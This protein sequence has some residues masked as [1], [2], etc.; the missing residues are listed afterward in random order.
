VSRNMP[1]DEVLVFGDAAVLPYP[2]GELRL[3]KIQDTLIA[4]DREPPLF[5][6]ASPIRNHLGP[7]LLAA[8][9]SRLTPSWSPATNSDRFRNFPFFLLVCGRIMG[10]FRIQFLENYAFFFEDLL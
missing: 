8:L 6:P 9:S 3:H 5:A 10:S 7:P 4:V 1:L 2:A